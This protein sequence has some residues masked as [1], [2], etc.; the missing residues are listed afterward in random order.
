MIASTFLRLDLYSLVVESVS[1]NRSSEDRHNGLRVALY[2]LQHYRFRKIMPARAEL[3]E[4]NCT[5]SP[6][7]EFVGV[8]GSAGDETEM[9]LL[10]ALR[11]YIISGHRNVELQMPGFEVP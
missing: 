6:C 8:I 4:L 2:S 1:L 5:H 9:R 7:H 3:Q 11:G 10:T